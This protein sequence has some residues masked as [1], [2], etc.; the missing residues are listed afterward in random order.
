[1][2]PD[3]ARAHNNLG[4]V[5]AMEGD[6]DGAIRHFETALELVPGFMDATNNLKRALTDR[7]KLDESHNKIE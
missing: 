7:R 5:L 4:V 1:M 6:F 2:K 3:Y